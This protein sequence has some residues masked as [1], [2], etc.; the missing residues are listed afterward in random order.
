VAPSKATLGSTGRDS[1]FVMEALM[2]GGAAIDLKRMQDE[3]DEVGKELGVT[4]EIKEGPWSRQG[5]R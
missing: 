4:M 2:E 1:L 3:L 5:R